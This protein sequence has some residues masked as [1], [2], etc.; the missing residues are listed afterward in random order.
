MQLARQ[1]CDSGHPIVVGV[2]GSS[3]KLPG[4]FVEATGVQ[5]GRITIADPGYESRTFLDDGPYANEFS[6]RGF[7]GD[8]PG[9]MSG[10]DIYVDDA[11]LLE[12]RVQFW[13]T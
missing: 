4:H 8:P 3:G 11:D 9:Y 5:D 6:V 2:R 10:L 7:V 13:S 12:H 1:L